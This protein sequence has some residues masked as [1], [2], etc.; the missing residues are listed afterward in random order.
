M[1]NLETSLETS[2]DCFVKTSRRLTL[3][4]RLFA[5]S[6]DTD[7]RDNLEKLNTLLHWAVSFENLDVIHFLVGIFFQLPVWIFTF[8]KGALVQC[9]LY[10]NCRTRSIARCR[11]R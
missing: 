2:N 11:K 8:I 6:T 3:M 1:L 9:L 5:A 7:I 10:C 4:K